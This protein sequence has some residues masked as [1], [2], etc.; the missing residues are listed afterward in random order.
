MW[1]T[2]IGL[3]FLLLG[4]ACQNAPYVRFRGTNLLNH[5]YVDM[6]HVGDFV[7]GSNNVQCHTD[8]DTCCSAE[9]GPDRGDWYFP[10]MSRLLFNY[11]YPI[12]ERRYMH[13][14][15]LKRSGEGG[16]SGIYRCDIETVAVHNASGRERVY[17]GLYGS[18]GEN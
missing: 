9:E 14:V 16:P 12:F 18:G 10:N 15:D 8:L 4:V 5:S 7:S 2:V 1:S 3:A 17:V 13:R 6:S 11:F